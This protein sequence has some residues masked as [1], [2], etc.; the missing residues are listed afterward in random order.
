MNMQLIDWVIVAS[1]LALVTIMAASTKRFTRGVADFLAAN[2]CAGRY[3]VSVSEGMAVLGAVTIVARFEAF[4]KAGFSIVWWGLIFTL[5]QVVLSLSGWVLYR[6][7]Q[8][9]VLTLAQFFEVRYS[10]R[11]RIFAGLLAWVTGVIN[12][13][14]FPAVG[15]RFFMYFCGFSET[16]MLLGI[17]I[18]TYSLIMFVLLAF[19]LFFVFVGGQIAVILTD[20]IQGLFCNIVF[21]IVIVFFLIAFDWS[22]I[23][24]ALAMAPKEAS[25]V[26]PF[27]TSQAEDFNIWFY[28]ISAFGLFYHYMS[29]QGNQGYNASA[30]SAHEAKM[31]KVLGTW[32]SLPLTSFMFILA[33]GSYTLMHHPDFESLAQSARAI[34]GGI[35][36]KAIQDQVTTPVAMGQFLPAGL[37][38][39]LCAV[40][41][42]AFISTHDTYLHSWGSIFIQDVVM[43]FR[44]KPFT[45]KQHLL[46]LRLSIVFVAVFIFIFSHVFRQTDYILM[47]F[48][49]TGAI[50][51]GGAGSVIVGG[52]YWKRGTTAAAWGSMITGSTLA[53]SGVIVKQL[54]ENCTINDA[55]PFA[56]MIN[57]AIGFFQQ[58]N[59]QVLAFVVMISSIVVYLLVSL[60]GK[61]QEYNMDRML[62]RGKYAVNED[63]SDSPALPVRG[64]KALI[65]INREFTRRDKILY[66]TTAAWSLMW[67]GIFIVGTI[68]NLIFDVSTESWEKFWYFY[69]I[70]SLV[71]GIVITIWFFIGGMHDIKDMFRT[72]REAKRNDLDD[73]M[74]IGHHNLAD[75]TKVADENK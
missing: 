19:A 50:F 8:T 21:V 7:R 27:Q 23:T 68:Y 74:V 59:G 75:E 11:F 1:L 69:I 66:I 18:P 44:K 12:F 3:L 47:F 20:F 58:T 49:I 13:G 41:L 10:K 24:E 40:M 61:K 28:L 5:A 70:L 48:A 25:M 16:T 30:K 17:G 26:N 31:G 72:L 37:M 56:A 64:F 38:G 33:I 4:Y 43:P 35:E 62:H 60:L 65:G 46:L 6:Y 67:V 51:T 53:V 71:V 36:G 2:R 29:W 57:K 54:P 45:S 52:L 73:G 39:A 42:A 15:A 55:A 32:R 34:L 22:Q 9:R 14:I 63:K